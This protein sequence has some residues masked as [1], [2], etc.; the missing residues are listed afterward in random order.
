MYLPDFFTFKFYGKFNIFEFHEAANHD[1]PL[2]P[3]HSAWN[4]G[5]P[6][7]D[8]LQVSFH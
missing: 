2:S 5:W 3:V 7:T 8:F 1:Y 6:I 4:S